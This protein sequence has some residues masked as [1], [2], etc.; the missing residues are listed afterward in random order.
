MFLGLTISFMKRKYVNLDIN[1]Q[2][3]LLIQI[4]SGIH[5]MQINQII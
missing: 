2:V 1:V 3:I 4:Q 5:A